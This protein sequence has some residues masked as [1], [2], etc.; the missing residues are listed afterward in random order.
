VSVEIYPSDDF[1]E[2]MIRIERNGRSLV[3]SAAN[4]I[5]F[6]ELDYYPTLAGIH[7][8]TVQDLDDDG[9]QEIVL[10]VTT[11]G[12]SCCTQI[13]ALYFD[14]EQQIYQHTNYIERK[15]SLSPDFIDIE[16]DGRPEFV[17]RNETYN[18]LAGGW[19]QI[20]AISPIQIFRYEAQAIVDVTDQYPRFIEQD[21][22][23]WLAAAK[24]EVAK[25]VSEK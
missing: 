10:D 12:A 7:I 9:E 5:L 25:A 18:E 3:E 13:V 16:Q 17:T 11:H 2:L 14:Q 6:G 24:S 19:D 8:L 21:A 23:I 20:A 1:T 22:K 4:P 15:W